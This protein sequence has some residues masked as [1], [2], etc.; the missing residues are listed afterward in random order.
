MVLVS[1]FIFKEDS[2]VENVK[3]GSNLN[4]FNSLKRFLS[5]FEGKND[6]FVEVFSHTMKYNL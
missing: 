4:F 1:F 3:A 5:D 2:V 6:S